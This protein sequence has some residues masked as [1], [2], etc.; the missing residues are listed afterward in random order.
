VVFQFPSALDE[1]G[2]RYN[3]RAE[4]A[5]LLNNPEG[6]ALLK[7]YQVAFKRRCMF[8][9]GT[10]MTFGDYRPTFNIHIKTRENGGA[11]HHGYPDPTYLERCLEELAAS[12]VTVKDIDL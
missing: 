1:E 3:S 6:V 9:L 5:I 2:R 7:L 4:Q 11:A 10:S 8:G 12:G